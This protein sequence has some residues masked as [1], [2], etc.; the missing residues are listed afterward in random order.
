MHNQCV[1]EGG[2][3]HMV[4]NNNLYENE[5]HLETGPTENVTIRGLTFT[6]DLVNDLQWGS[7]SV[8]LSNPGSHNVRFID[9]QWVDLCAPSNLIYVGINTF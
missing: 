1:F 7:A 9:C 8:I 2:Q 3:L 6:G 5:C 4:M